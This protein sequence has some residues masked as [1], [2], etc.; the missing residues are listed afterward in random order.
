MKSKYSSNISDGYV[1]LKLICALSVKCVLYLEALVQKDVKSL[2]VFT[3]IICWNDNRYI[4]LN[5][6]CY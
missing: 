6:I 4:G 2:T 5:K 1:V 3:L